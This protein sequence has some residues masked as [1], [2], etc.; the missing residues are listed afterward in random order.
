MSDQQQL[1]TEQVADI[2]EL[3]TRRYFD[4]YLKNVLPKQME[5]AIKIHDT[6]DQ[7]HGGVERRFNKMQHLLIGFAAAGGLGAGTVLNQI[8]PFI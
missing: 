2:A 4:H 1:T 6:D 3:T 8:L 7:S 5:T